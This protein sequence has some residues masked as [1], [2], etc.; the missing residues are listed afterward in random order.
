MEAM[1]EDTRTED[2]ALTADAIDLRGETADAAP[3]V[4]EHDRIAQLEAE[5]AEAKAAT[6]YARADAQN[7]LRRAEKEA[8][9]SRTYAITGFARDLL[10]VADN[11]ARGLAAIPAE[12]RSHRAMQRRESGP[13]IAAV[14]QVV[15]IRN[16]IVD[17]TA[18]MT[19]RRA[20][21]HAAPALPA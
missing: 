7:M 21:I 14:G 6:L 10:S 3:E 20:A 4:A 13:H 15:P 19:I 2:P 12:L 16:Q 1:S 5:L 11:L 8:Q 9:D 18:G 17:R